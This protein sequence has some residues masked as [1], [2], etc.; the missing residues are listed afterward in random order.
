MEWLELRAK[1][2]AFFSA[3]PVRENATLSGTFFGSKRRTSGTFTVHVTAAPANTSAHEVSAVEYITPSVLENA[4]P[5][6]RWQLLSETR[7]QLQLQLRPHS[8]YLANG[9]M[10]DGRADHRSVP[11]EE[12]VLELKEDGKLLG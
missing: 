3:T 5:P 8:A 9:K 11:M 7:A 1:S 6:S 10:V 2:V 4:G 12:V